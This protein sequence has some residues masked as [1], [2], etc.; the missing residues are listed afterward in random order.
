[1]VRQNEARSGKSRVTEVWIC[2][3]LDGREDKIAME[4]IKHN[5]SHRDV[6]AR[7]KEE[8]RMGTNERRGE[9]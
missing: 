1:V 7:R 2:F 6:I 5:Q 9:W 8:Q 4:R 3:W